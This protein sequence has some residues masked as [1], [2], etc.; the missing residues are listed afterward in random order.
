MIDKQLFGGFLLQR[1]CP[2]EKAWLSPPWTPPSLTFSQQALLSACT[3][4][5]SENPDS[6]AALCK[7]P[8]AGLLRGGL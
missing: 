2:G 3:T 8:Q 1:D 7:S 6:L 5:G 4:V